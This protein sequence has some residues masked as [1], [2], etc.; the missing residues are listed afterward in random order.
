MNRRQLLHGALAASITP[1][2]DRMQHLVVAPSSLQFPSSS[3]AS[4]A[5]TRLQLDVAAAQ[6]EYL[7]VREELRHVVPPFFAILDLARYQTAAP[8]AL[9]MLSPLPVG[10]A[11]LGLRTL[12]LATAHEL[13]SWQTGAFRFTEL[14]QLTPDEAWALVPPT[15]RAHALQFENLDS[16]GVDAAR[17]LVAA[18]AG[19][20]LYVSLAQASDA[21]VRELAHHDH[22]LLV[23]RPYGSLSDLARQMLD[24][25][26]R[27][28][29][30][31]RNV[32]TSLPRS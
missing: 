16:L 25:Q 9:R 26:E 8:A 15:G 31:R 12:G 13:A 6:Q 14:R 4:S 5:S 1:H 22:E 28:F 18:A 19:A 20:S 21:T 10:W 7:Q 2:V 3:A 11:D 32:T 27:R 24:A 17:G 29:R 30:R 23:D